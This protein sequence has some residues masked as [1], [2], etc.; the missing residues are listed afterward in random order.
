MNCN[1]FHLKE[2]GVVALADGPHRQVK[3]VD[4]TRWP[5]GDGTN[6]TA[7]VFVPNTMV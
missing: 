6:S 2:G 4:Q 5:L 3:D 1:V 7:V